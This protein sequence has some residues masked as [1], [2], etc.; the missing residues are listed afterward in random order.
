MLLA[1]L[2]QLAQLRR[3]LWVVGPDGAALPWV[4]V[5]SPVHPVLRCVLCAH[6]LNA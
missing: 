3:M 1:S 5:D 4:R 2:K 6:R